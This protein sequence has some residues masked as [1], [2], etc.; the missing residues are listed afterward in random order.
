M[1]AW[2]VLI[3]GGIITFAT[4]L[5]FIFLLGRIEIPGWLR[6]SLRFVPPAVL[7]AIVAPELLLHTGSLN[8]SFTNFR[9]LAG[10]LAIVIAWR[11]RN[12]LLTITAGMAALL[13]LQMF[14]R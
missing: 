13:L 2:W 7:S 4:R 8:I 1:S 5:S 6:R 9:L 3:S 11:T 10:L 12:A 14:L